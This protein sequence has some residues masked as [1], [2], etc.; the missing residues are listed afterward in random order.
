MA[1]R[2]CE[3]PNCKKYVHGYDPFA[4]QCREH[5]RPGWLGQER[6]DQI[7]AAVSL[8][9]AALVAASRLQGPYEMRTAAVRAWAA[10]HGL[11]PAETRHACTTFSRIRPVAEAMALR[12]GVDAPPP[13]VAPRQAPATVA[14]FV[15]DL[16]PTDEM[17]DILNAHP[18]DRYD[19]ERG[20]VYFLSHDPRWMKVGTSFRDLIGRMRG[21]RDSAP[22]VPYE[23]HAVTGHG[24]RALERAAHR[25]LQHHRVT[26]EW[27]VRPA[28]ELLLGALRRATPRAF[29]E[30][31]RRS[32]QTVFD[33]PIVVRPTKYRANSDGPVNERD[34][35]KAAK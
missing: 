24:G 5:W 11:T 27:F 9:A 28:A 32:A 33:A 1:R 2:R 25:V 17:I 21:Y 26:G 7:A 10:R 31:A 34:E 23:V 22:G 16:G 20:V 35:R 4:T 14:A 30:P 12:A 15:G 3:E 8:D 29:D 13:V 18:A 6:M 19:D